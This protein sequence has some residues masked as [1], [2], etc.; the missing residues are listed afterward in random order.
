MQITVLYFA[1]L[2]EQLGQA[3]ACLQLPGD[4]WT[5]ASLRT[6][7]CASSDAHALAL[8]SEASIQAAVNQRMAIATTVV[9]AGAEVAFFPPVTGG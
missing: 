3:S 7:L 5:V 1:S 6:Y 2:R 8:A 9:P 4:D